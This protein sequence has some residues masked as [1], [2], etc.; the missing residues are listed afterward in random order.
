MVKNYSNV[1]AF[2][3]AAARRGPV[4]R[5]LVHARTQE[6]ASIAGR[7]PE[8][9][10][11]SDYE[12]AKREL[13]G[14][15]DLDRQN[16]ILDAWP[17]TPRVDSAPGFSREDPDVG[18]RSKTRLTVAAGLSSLGIP[19]DSILKYETALKTNKYVLLAHGSTDEITQARETL[20]RTGPETLDHHK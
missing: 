7:K 16:A 10:T 4:T 8:A 15:S 13:T 3:V 17:E 12:Q 14:E 1:G 6:L 9:V 18:G 11:Q 5:A 20:G 2:L 19:K